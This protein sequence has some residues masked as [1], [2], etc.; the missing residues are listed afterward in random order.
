MQPRRQQ[1]LDYLDWQERQLTRMQVTIRRNAPVDAD[2]V[3]AFGADVVVL[4]TGSQPTGEGFQRALPHLDRLPGIERG[5][6]CSAE[7]VMARE[8]R[9]GRRVVLLDEGANWKGADTALA[10]AEA[11]H[12]VTIVTPAGMV[13]KEVERTAA[14]IPIRKRL[15]ELGARFVTDAAVREWRGDAAV[16]TQFAGPDETI[17]ADTLVIA[18]CNRPEDGI[19][20]ELVDGSLDV[21]SVG[22]SVAART[23]VMAIYE[24]R[25]AGMAI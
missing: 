2:E 20:R 5:N 22:D 4:A 1:I 24:G 10:L 13:A 14:D 9:P 3:R 6:V 16:V 8:A 12:A 15:R 18:A 17:P 7:A 21:R 19:A 25:V 11:G 23:A